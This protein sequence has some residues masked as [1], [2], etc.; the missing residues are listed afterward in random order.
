MDGF[1]LVAG[2]PTPVAFV[3]FLARRRARVPRLRR[4]DRARRCA[5][6]AER[7]DDALARGAALA[8]GS[9]TLVSEA[10]RE[11]TLR[12][13]EPRAGARA[14]RCSSTPT[15]ARRAGTTSTTRS[16]SAASSAT[17]AFVVRT[18]REEARADHRRGRPRGRGRADLRAGRDAR[19]SSRWGPTGRW[20]AARRRRT[21]RASR[22]RSSR[23]SA[24]GT[25]SSG[26]LA[27]GLA[28]L[29][30]DA[31]RAA[32]ALPAAVA[33]SSEACTR[34]GAWA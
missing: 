27:A 6:A 34:W 7:L 4:G 20:C 23:R 25:P 24:P 8:F 14:S 29:G 18:N 15:C 31:S 33:A 13:R 17:D 19:A 22:S 9:N 26:T 30:W 3:T 32:E 2:A 21:P 16:S 5:A 11:L 10:E 12:A 1:A 28:R